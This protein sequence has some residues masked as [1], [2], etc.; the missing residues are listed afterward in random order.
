MREN[1]EGESGT[2]RKA[3]GIRRRHDKHAAEP[4]PMLPK[5]P[6]KGRKGCWEISAPR[7]KVD[8]CG[9]PETHAFSPPHSLRFSLIGI[10]GGRVTSFSSPF[11][12]M[13]AAPLDRIVQ[14]ESKCK[15]G[16]LEK[17]KK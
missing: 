7:N 4:I 17:K 3:I 15:K 13:A 16:N 9:E 2:L 6:Y 14:P 5:G 8:V 11:P 12:D 1:Q 10:R